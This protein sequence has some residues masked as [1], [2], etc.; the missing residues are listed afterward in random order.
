MRKM[1]ITSK[2]EVLGLDLD[3]TLTFRTKLPWWCSA[4][5]MPFFM[6]L[7][8]NKPM[9]DV[10][11]KVRK[12]GGKVIIIS[13][14][15]RFST[16]LSKLWLRHYKVPYNKIKC[17]GFI[18]R[19]IHKLEV[20]RTESIDCFIDDDREMRRFVEESEPLIKILGSLV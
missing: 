11:E 4:L 1:R 17:V 8:P 16:R 20:I 10:I 7:P 18:H 3:N 2:I 13:A 14:R 12:A 9:L 15:P 19:K 5:L 6:I